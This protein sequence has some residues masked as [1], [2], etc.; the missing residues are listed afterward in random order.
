[1]QIDRVFVEGLDEEQQRTD[2]TQRLN[3]MIGVKGVSIDGHL[4][5][6]TLKYETPMNLNTLEK[7]IYDAGFKVLRTVKGE[8]TNE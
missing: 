5:C 7:E 4:Q 8:I 6:V 2:L 1:M 3:H